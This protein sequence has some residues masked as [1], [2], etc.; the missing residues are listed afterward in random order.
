MI[1]VFSLLLALGSRHASA[2]KPPWTEERLR[3]SSSLIVVGTVVSTRLLD[4]KLGPTR[5]R[6]SYRSE[7]KITSVLKGDKKPGD[8]IQITWGTVRWV[9]KG[10]KPPG[11][12]I[13]PTFYPC[14]TVKV[15]LWGKGPSYSVTGW[16]GLKHIKPPPSHKMPVGK[17]GVVRCKDG[18]PTEETPRP[19]PRPSPRTAPKAGANKPAMSGKT[20]GSGSRKSKGCGC[21]TDP[22]RFPSF[23]FLLLVAGVI[24]FLV[25]DPS[26]QEVD[27]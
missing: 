14:E 4:F 15:Y 11:H 27:E 23:P 6:G 24:L 9:G 25:R 5:A 3:N 1:T 20:G 26:G 18:R 10:R 19:P 17:G 13:Y 7:F 21:R 2:I 12:W 16:N 8:L 22:R